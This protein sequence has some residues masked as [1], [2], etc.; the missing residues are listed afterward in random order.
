MCF[1][2]V[3]FYMIFF[4][5]NI[6]RQLLRCT[7]TI[8]HIQSNNGSS[9]KHEDVL[10]IRSITGSDNFYV[11]Y[12]RHKIEIHAIMILMLLFYNCDISCCRAE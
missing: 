6:F 10:G 5:L 3:A 12:L 7:R 11:S 2:R 4:Y 8:S 9:A 1:N